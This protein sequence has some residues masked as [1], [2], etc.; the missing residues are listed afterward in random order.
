M[1]RKVWLGLGLS[2]SFSAM[3]AFSVEGDAA[4]TMH[5][6]YNPNSGEHFYTANGIEKDIL[7]RAGW[8]YEGT[9]WTAP[10]TGPNVYRMYNANAGDHHYTMNPAEKDMLVRVG[11][12]YEGVGW[13]TDDYNGVALHRLYDPNAKAGSHH[14]T[15]NAGERDSLA[16]IGW[17]KE[18]LGWYGMNPNQKFNVKIVH[19]GSDGKT[20]NQETV[21]VARD[22]NFTARA[23]SFNDYR[24]NGNDSQTIK[25]DTD[26]KT[27]TFTYKKK[28]DLNAIANNV[29][30][31]ALNIINEFRRTEKGL[32]ALAH[33][34]FL[35]KGTNVRAKEIEQRFA[36]VRPNGGS[37]YDAVYDAG[38]PGFATG[39]NIGM[40]G[41][42]YS[43][44]DIK[45]NSAKSLVDIWK[46]STS[47][48]REYLLTDE[49]DEAAVGVYIT[50]KDGGYYVWFVFMAGNSG[51]APYSQDNI[52]TEEP[53][54]NL[55]EYNM[56]EE[57]Q[58]NPEESQIIEEP[59]SD[60]EEK[61][62]IEK[63]Q[64]NPEENQTVEE[65]SSEE[66]VSLDNE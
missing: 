4:Q 66:E 1:K 26:N 29:S 38:Y 31:D 52:V 2:L 33:N 9:G 61:Q 8:N 28:E 15:T 27:V 58:S 60:S 45:N 37:I 21:S 7:V 57:P 5:R 48:H 42:N 35:Q 3:V 11:W 55:E 24:L 34:A 56:I 23:K 43:I 54:S 6:M 39:E 36:H 22:S 44:E 32:P 14:Y 46:S 18:G 65:Q 40:F 30:R 53:Q 17:R 10:D 13:K 20:L 62:I 63:P 59:Q 25:A 12:N 47:G 50:E 16:T 49:S 19:K 64:A 41:G 51:I